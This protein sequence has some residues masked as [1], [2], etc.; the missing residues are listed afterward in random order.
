MGNHTR[1]R[2]ELVAAL[3]HEKVDKLLAHLGA[4][5]VHGVSHSTRGECGQGT[6]DRWQQRGDAPPSNSLP[7][8]RVPRKWPLGWLQ[9]KKDG[10]DALNTLLY[11]IGFFARQIYGRRFNLSDYAG[12]CNFPA[13][14]VELANCRIF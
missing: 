7:L 11:K 3:L 10:K 13:F 2:P 12:S 5:R 14:L 1:R 6:R 8:T 9:Y 4:R